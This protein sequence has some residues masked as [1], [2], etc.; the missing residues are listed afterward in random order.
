M[1]KKGG[2]DNCEQETGDGGEQGQGI[3]SGGMKVP[4]NRDE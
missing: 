1:T 2:S 4:I 3:L